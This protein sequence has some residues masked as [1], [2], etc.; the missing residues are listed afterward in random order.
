MT[1]IEMYRC[2]NTYAH[3]GKKETSFGRCSQSSGY[4]LPTIL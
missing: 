3:F 2:M 4:F 1:P